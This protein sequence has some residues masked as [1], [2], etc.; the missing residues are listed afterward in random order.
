MLENYKF[1]HMPENITMTRIHRNQDTNTSP[2][3]ITEGNP[4]WINIAKDY[5]LEKKIALEGSEYLFYKEMET[6]L[7]TTPYEEA[8]LEVK[9]LAEQCLEE[10]KNKS[11]KK[12]VTVIISSN[13]NEEDLINTIKSIKK[14]TFKNIEIIVL[15]KTKDKKVISVTSK[16]EAIENIFCGI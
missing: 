8:V 1:I 15:G 5:P 3:V 11:N 12:S 10:L 2:R 9:K 14:Q 7:K 6:Y 4:L 16:K 13:D